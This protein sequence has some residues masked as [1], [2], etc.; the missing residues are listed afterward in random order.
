MINQNNKAQEQAQG[1]NQESEKLEP[2]FQAAKNRVRMEREEG[3]G[4]NSQGPSQFEYIPNAKS[5]QNK[6]RTIPQLTLGKEGGTAEIIENL[7]QSAPLGSLSA[8]DLSTNSIS[9]L[10]TPTFQNEVVDIE[11]VK[12]EKV[13][14]LLNFFTRQCP[15]FIAFEGVGHHYS[16]LP[17]TGFQRVIAP[18]TYLLTCYIIKKCLERNIQF[19]EQ[20]AA[21]IL[22]LTLM[23]TLI[24]QSIFIDPNNFKIIF[25]I[26]TFIAQEEYFNVLMSTS[27]EKK[28]TQRI[29][30]WGYYVIRNF[31]QYGHFPPDLLFH[32]C[33]HIAVQGLSSSVF[34][35]YIKSIALNNKMV[36][37]TFQNTLDLVPN[38]V[39]IYD[40]KLKCITYTNS[41]MSDIVEMKS[42]FSNPGKVNLEVLK[43]KLQQFQIHESGPRSSSPNNQGTRHESPVQF[44]AS[45]TPAKAQLLKLKSGSE[46]QILSQS[47]PEKF[48]AQ[49]T[50]RLSSINVKNQL[51][52]AVGG[53]EA[54]A[55]SF[56]C[57]SSKISRSKTR[58]Q[59][60]N[61]WQFIIGMTNTENR[62][63]VNAVFKSKEP[64]R[65]I[66]VKTSLI[67][68]GTQIIAIC[69]D[70][71]SVKEMEMQGQ[72]MRATFFS[73]VAHELRTPLNSIIP[74]LKMVLDLMPMTGE[75][76]QNYLKVVLN[77]SM[78][79][80]SV[81]E[82]ALDI[83]R[84][85]NNKFTLYKEQF[86]IRAAVN[87][88][89]EIMKFQIDQK[90]LGMEIQINPRIPLKIYTDQKRFKQVLFNLIGNAI[91]FT[92]TGSI[93]VN[94][95][96][97]EDSNS[98]VADVIDTGIGIKPED[99][100]K[101]FQFFG[102]LSKTKDIN[103]GGMGLGLTIS[104]M[105]VQQLG[106]EMTVTSK[107]DQGSK[108]T[109]TLPLDQFDPIM[110]SKSLQ[111]I[112]EEGNKQPAA[113][114]TLLNL[115]TFQNSSGLAIS[116]QNG[117]SLEGFQ[118]INNP[119]N[120]KDSY[121]INRSQFASQQRS[122]QNV[123]SNKLNQGSA[124]SSETS[125]KVSLDE[126]DCTI[127]GKESLNTGVMQRSQNLKNEGGREELAK[128]QPR[129]MNQARKKDPHIACKVYLSDRIHD[130][131][132][133]TPS[134][135]NGILSY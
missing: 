81:I 116:Q 37:E 19:A 120:K 46:R 49:G 65:Y 122:R 123:F 74:I 127:Q 54:S 79:L 26:L 126:N 91:K 15:V 76:M 100:M 61:L 68:N 23:V 57:S 133:A 33:I 71:T 94:L 42:L 93:T 21:F 103:R 36:T 73:S 87:E 18:Y 86:D 41:E 9:S 115:N 50:K 88:V 101:L 85:E 28:R 134:V 32:V 38:G 135:K 108:F 132:S 60:K 45:N 6:D 112:E 99:L 77:S 30:V 64:R 8:K 84:L 105:I 69:T 114:P 56:L 67:N 22:N 48:Q 124:L 24:E 121:Q 130:E 58:P 107:P 44:T 129:V 111:N 4:S 96:T 66:Q 43:D 53:G 5:G 75:R 125:L 62:F 51:N 80:Q 119:Q 35:T 102:T 29:V 25:V 14:N 59:K 3:E 20:H 70:I 7:P 95:S 110:F 89:C 128:T 27:V 34:D 55:T 13:Y 47:R 97:D 10:T 16:D 104:K 131:Q 109:F 117:S 92:Y 31:I 90:S 17:G 40:I 63:K 72:K 118:N 52:N 78:H 98:L 2:Y 11:K 39:L 106:G 82:D 113:T 83:S 12:R 1:I